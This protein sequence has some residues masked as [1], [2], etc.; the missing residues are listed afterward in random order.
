MAAVVVTDCYVALCHISSVCTIFITFC[1]SLIW[2]CT[3]ASYTLLVFAYLVFCVR[4]DSTVWQLF[5]LTFVYVWQHSSSCI[6]DLHS[7][8][9]KYY[10]F[11]QFLGI[12]CEKMMMM[13]GWRNAWSMKLRVQDQE[14]D[15]RGPGKRLCERT[16]KLV[17]WI[18]RMPRTV[19]DGERW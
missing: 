12:C 16:V 4:V 8:C 5:G 2:Y 6:F 11:H 19:A 1:P 13:I 14:E 18:K 9:N 17:S 10:R 7:S 15:Q 3:T